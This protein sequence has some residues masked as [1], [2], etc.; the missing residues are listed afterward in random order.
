MTI[1]KKG[2]SIL[3]WICSQ[4]PKVGKL[5]IT[6]W[7]KI[8]LVFGWSPHP[9]LV[10]VADRLNYRFPI[11]TKLFNNMR[12]KVDWND[13]GV[14]FKIYHNGVY[15]KNTVQIISQLLKPGDIFMD[16]GA[17]C[18]QYTLIASRS[19]GETGQVHSFEP[20]PETFKLLSKSVQLNNLANVYLNQ[21]A[22]SSQEG[23]RHLYFASSHCTGASSLS[24]PYTYSDVNCEVKC[25]T[26]DSYIHQ[27]KVEE[28]DF[29]K[30]DIE[31][32]EIDALKGGNLLFSSK[33]S[34][35]IITEFNEQTQNYFGSTCKD[36]AEFLIN[37]KY[38]LYII[39]GESPL[40]VLAIPYDK[41]TLINDLN[42][43]NS[44]LKPYCL[45]T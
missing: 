35:I 28:V 23:I 34:P 27:N 12:I 39:G 29:L 25:T 33:N 20:D 21:L 13:L 43:E 41:K 15:E 11:Q 45:E 44:V 42:D 7:V 26:I 22:L 3:Y 30:I 19:V 38:E 10:W 1:G 36:L 9:G 24:T 16:A 31:G 5:I 40:N 37:R 32:H 4:Y 8:H 6:I 2:L 18:G 17:H 14:G